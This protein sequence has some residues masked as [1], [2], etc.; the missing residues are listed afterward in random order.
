MNSPFLLDRSHGAARLVLTNTP[1]ETEARARGLYRQIL[2]RDP[3]QQESN[4]SRQFVEQARSSAGDE[5]A[6][7]GQ[8]AQVLLLSNEFLFVD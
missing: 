7:W 1:P 2:G 8:L 5:A 6:V 4:L 3:S